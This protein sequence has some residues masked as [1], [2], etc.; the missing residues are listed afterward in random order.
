[1]QFKWAYFSFNLNDRQPV[2]QNGLFNF[3]SIQIAIRYLEK[4]TNEINERHR[5][6]ACSFF[7]YYFFFQLYIFHPIKID[8]LQISIEPLQMQ[9][10]KK[11][12]K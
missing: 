3:L 10:Q 1:M 11:K 9:M 4:R 7:F 8:S 6:E 5:S 2:E 12:Q